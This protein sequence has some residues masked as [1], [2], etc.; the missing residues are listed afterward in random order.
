ME[1]D[2]ISEQVR[3]TTE[4]VLAKDRL[5]K[6]GGFME[7]HGRAGARCGETMHVR[8]A[9]RWLGL[10]QWPRFSQSGGDASA[11]DGTKSELDE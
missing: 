7:Q 10:G 6:T 5:S 9:A 11:T 3:Q 4:F 2:D 1:V 8:S